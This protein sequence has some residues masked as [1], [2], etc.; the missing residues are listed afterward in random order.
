MKEDSLPEN[1]KF[2]VIDEAHTL[3]SPV[4]EET[5]EE[6]QKFNEPLNQGLKKLLRTTIDQRKKSQ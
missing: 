3:F 1:T 2:V 4:T 6:L 5:R